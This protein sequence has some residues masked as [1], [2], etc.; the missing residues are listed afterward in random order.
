MNLLSQ[1]RI[2]VESIKW[3]VTPIHRLQATVISSFFPS[4]FIILFSQYFA[5]IFLQYGNFFLW[6]FTDEG[7]WL[8]DPNNVICLVDFVVFVD[9]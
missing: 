8:D 5:C 4:Q 6:I 3:A 9:V 2:F 7:V 1:V